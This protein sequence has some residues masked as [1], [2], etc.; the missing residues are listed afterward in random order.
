MI[1]LLLQEI[2][3]HPRG[4]S[5]AAEAGQQQQPAPLGVVAVAVPPDLVDHLS[6]DLV[7]QPWSRQAPLDD[8]IPK[9]VLLGTVEVWVPH[10][11]QHL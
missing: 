10:E 3:F 5:E 11:A 9:H 4:G 7:P 8:V 2:F 1:L 6:Q